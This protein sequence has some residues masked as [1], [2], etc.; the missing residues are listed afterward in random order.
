MDLSGEPGVFGKMSDDALASYLETAVAITQQD[1]KENQILYYKPVS[2]RALRF[3][4]STAKVLAAGGGNRSSKTTS[5]LVHM[6]MCSTGV[7]PYSLRHLVKTHFRGPINCRLVVE[8]LTTTLEPVIIPK[9]QYMH[10][11]GVDSPGGE[12]GH[13]GWIPKNCLIDGEWQRSWS[14][15]LRI[16]RLLCR[17]PENPDRVLGES[18]WQCMSFDQDP[19]D[20]ASGEFHIIGHDEPPGHAQWQ[21]NE[22]RAM[23]VG[24]RLLLAMT[25]PDDPSINVDWLYNEV[26]EPARAGTNPNIEWLELWTQE[27]MQVDQ[28][29]IA[30]QAAKWSQE[31][32]DVRLFGRPIRF[33]NRIHPE[34]TDN[35][36]TW[37]FP[38]DKAIIPVPSEYTVAGV[39]PRRVCS[40]CQGENIV[41]FNH[42]QEFSASSTW[43][44]VFLI[45]PH[46]RKKH[47]LLWVQ[48]SPSDDWFVV[49]DAQVDGDCV[50]VRKEAERIEALY[51][52]QV[53][54]RLTDP[55]MGMSPASHLRVAGR[56]ITWVDEFRSA[57]LPLDLAQDSE[58]GRA[59]INTMLKPDSATL[60]PRAVFHPRCKDT[61]YMMV[62]YVWDNF[63][64]KIDKDPKQTP[65][66]KYDDF[67]TLLKYLAN[68]EPSFRFLKGNT[69]TL[70][71]P[72]KRK[73]S[74]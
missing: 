68:S 73:G 60:Q 30:E 4:E 33:S 11:S 55:N 1:R 67:P 41:D 46:P 47:C 48:I 22:A 5:M 10:W 9:L 40:H 39:E 59:R 28:V 17:D 20:F 7:F 52:L 36:K 69:P 65:K 56:P 3:H 54:Q 2:P 14:A 27:N 57:G 21:E 18:S 64:T 44:T 49:A 74:Y 71:R 53:A 43:P 70:K 61:V 12:R 63:S 23:S 26:Y 72:G 25:W 66:Q 24:G 45:D 13:W 6:V 34:F 62:R 15:K 31:L 38:C 29:S 42:V 37:C 16:I 51:G 58:V 8:S 35:T 50:D 32:N 19:S